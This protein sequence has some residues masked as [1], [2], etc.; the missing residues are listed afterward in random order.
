MTPPDVVVGANGDG[1]VACNWTQGETA[2]YNPIHSWPDAAQAVGLGRPIPHG[3]ATY[4]V[5]CH[6]VLAACANLRPEQLAS[7]EGRFS[8]P[9][10]PGET[11]TVDLWRSD[12]DAWDFTARI[13][14]RGVVVMKAGRAELRG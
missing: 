8:A 7:L 14:T 2:L 9:F 11:I 1:L 12:P 13:E 6:G 3:P 4:G 10:Y 5:V